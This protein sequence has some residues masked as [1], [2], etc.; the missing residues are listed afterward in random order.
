MDLVEIHGRLAN[1]V[2]YYV[3]ILAIWGLWRVLRKEEVG[4]SYWGA[5]VI[6]EILI[7][8]Q[9]AFG[10]F[11]WLDSHRP[12]GGWMHTLYGAVGAI[13]L[14]AVYLFMKGRSDRK[15]MLLFGLVLLAMIAI[16]VRSIVTGG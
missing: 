15:G 12:L 11:L 1:T 6:A 2:L 14:P 13:S 10:V 8:V 4:S 16:V 7:L 3:A 9:V 5:L